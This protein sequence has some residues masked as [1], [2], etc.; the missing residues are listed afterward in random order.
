MEPN[1][2]Q[3]PPPAPIDGGEA[4]P[5]S[6]LKR[7]MIVLITVLAI[8]AAAYLLSGRSGPRDATNLVGLVGTE[9][10]EPLTLLE[11]G[12]PVEIEDMLREEM[13][14]RLRV[15]TIVGAD[16]VGVGTWD[17]GRNVRIPV[18]MYDDPSGDVTRV[19]VMNYAILD[20]I[21]AAVFLDK[22]IRMELEQDRSYAVVP[23]A[24]NREIVLWREGDDIFLAIADNGAGRLISRIMQ[25]GSGTQG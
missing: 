8:G 14:F 4:P 20:Q 21:S 5:G 25:P 18:V 23:G 16:I 22:S 15:P 11:T 19:I 13:G 1:A 17:A 12:D 10:I 7:T 6:G 2:E 24:D 9:P 3:S